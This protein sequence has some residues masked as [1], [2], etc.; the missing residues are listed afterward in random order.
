MGVRIKFLSII[1]HAPYYT[2]KLLNILD[3]I[4]SEPDQYSDD[5]TLSNAK[6][7]KQ[8]KQSK[9]HILLPA[10]RIKLKGRKQLCL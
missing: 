1:N 5:Q 7:L 2:I 8:G 9:T 3:F 10:T 4:I 6:N